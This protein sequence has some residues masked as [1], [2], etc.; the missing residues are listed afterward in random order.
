MS[1][2]SPVISTLLKR[3]NLAVVP[4]DQQELLGRPDAWAENRKDSSHGLVN[5][6]V[7]V[8]NS[9]KEAYKAG[10][11]QQ[12]NGEQ[13][14]HAVS[15]PHQRSTRPSQPVA[16]T[17]PQQEPGSSPP[18]SSRQ[19]RRF[20]QMSWPTTPARTE[21]QRHLPDATPR[22]VKTPQGLSVASP[23]RPPSR[24]AAPA[25]EF[26][27]EDEE[28]PS[29][30]HDTVVVRPA[31]ETPKPPSTPAPASKETY[32]SPGRVSNGPVTRSS[33]RALQASKSKPQVIET[34]PCAQPP[35]VIVPGTVMKE[36]GAVQ[37]SPKRNH[38]RMKP[39]TFDLDSQEI[40]QAVRLA[41]AKL[42]TTG[43]ASEVVTSSIIPASTV[44]STEG[45]TVTAPPDKGVLAEAAKVVLEKPDSS[46]NESTTTPSSTLQRPVT[47]ISIPGSPVVEE[48]EAAASSTAVIQPVVAT[49]PSTAVSVTSRAATID[50]QAI[51]STSNNRAARSASAGR[52]R[53]ALIDIAIRAEDLSPFD[54]FVAV[55]SKYIG[56]YSGSL[57]AFLRACICLD[58]LRKTRGLKED[59]YDDFI[60]AF[61]TYV[62]YV[63]KAGP[64]QSPLPAIEWY[65]EVAGPVIFLEQMV[66]KRNL[67]AV[68]HIYEAEV[69]ELR[70]FIE[71]H[72]ESDTEEMV[73]EVM[74]EVTEEVTEEV[75]E[76]VAEDAV[77]DVVL[78]TP[79]GVVD[80]PIDV[81]DNT[82]IARPEN[83]PPRHSD[84]SE[85]Q[86]APVNQTVRQA[87]PQLGSPMGPLPSQPAPASRPETRTCT[88]LASQYLKRLSKRAGSKR[89]SEEDEERFRRNIRR[90]LATM[91][92]P[93]SSSVVN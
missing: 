1:P 89:R 59:L 43:G 47:I 23:R 32:P 15:P 13:Q 71:G 57:R 42:F 22:I 60:R 56:E 54:A 93:P 40:Q 37:P 8:R 62:Q 90:K 69:A 81:D 30:D 17:P 24:K 73:E 20:T 53:S 16:S 21:S 68:L 80:D 82:D 52:R 18:P 49:T 70:G 72:A 12:T 64:G 76:D 51:A 35:R 84:D 91:Q 29:T 87:S 83:C 67:D 46:T 7:H 77:E 50:P 58:Y 44:E 79:G 66:T 28:D 34:P 65:N 2:S 25:F 85:R 3:R 31:P 38:R 10:A 55:Y 27:C 14:N 86:K 6:P 41:P 63:N 5:V 33:A 4:K 78:A 61:P 39:I 9:A 75:V 36:T 11:K 88:P 48:E 26:Q 19:S 92:V 45:T 74:E